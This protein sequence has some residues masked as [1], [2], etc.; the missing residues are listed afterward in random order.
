MGKE[1]YAVAVRTAKLSAVKPSKKAKIFL[2]ENAS[3]MIY[4]SEIIH[5]SKTEEKVKVRLLMV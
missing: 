4:P 2:R 3:R 1:L 5:L